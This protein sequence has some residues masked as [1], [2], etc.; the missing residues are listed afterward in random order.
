MFLG[1]LTELKHLF[2][3]KSNFLEC[4][5]D[6]RQLVT[7]EISHSYLK[8]LKLLD[9]LPIYSHLEELR[10]YHVGICDSIV[11]VLSNSLKNLTS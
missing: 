9:I 7:L 11:Q 4:T 3:H 6:H 2:I 10:L 1:G 5:D 8:I